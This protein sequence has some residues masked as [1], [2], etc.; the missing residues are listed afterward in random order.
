MKNYF[1][2]VKFN[3]CYIFFLPTDEGKCS[4]FDEIV[5]EL[6]DLLISEEFE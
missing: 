1:I 5:G 3:L 6:Q 2:K 4:K